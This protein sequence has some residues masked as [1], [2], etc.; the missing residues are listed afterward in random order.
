MSHIHNYLMISLLP[1]H[2]A[3]GNRDPAYWSHDHEVIYNHA[4][5][6]EQCPDSHN[7][8]TSSK[9]F[10]LTYLPRATSKCA[11]YHPNTPKIRRHAPL[12]SDKLDSLRR[13][14]IQRPHSRSL[15][16]HR[17]KM[18][19]LICLIVLTIFSK[20]SPSSLLECKADRTLVPP[21]GVF[22]VAGCGMDLVVNLIL[23]FLGYVSCSDG[24]RWSL[25]RAL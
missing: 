3:R 25:I 2:V 4:I 11:N 14:P 18:L 22:I 10:H 7:S 15:T 9:I 6:G 20:I 5:E 21:L 23:T 13:P 17:A 16:V 12:L 1:N 24:E 8:L 19:G